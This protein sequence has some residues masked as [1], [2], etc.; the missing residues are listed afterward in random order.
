MTPLSKYIYR[1]SEPAF[2]LRQIG[3]KEHPHTKLNDKEMK[4][5]VRL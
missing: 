1:E 5:F 3:S 2:F 4:N